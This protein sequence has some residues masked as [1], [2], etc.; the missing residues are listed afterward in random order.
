MPELRE[1]TEAD[2]MVALEQDTADLRER[3]AELEAFV[4]CLRGAAT[5]VRLPRG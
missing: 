1:S 5:E 2:R 4:A 3:I